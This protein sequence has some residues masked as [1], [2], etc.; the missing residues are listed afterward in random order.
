MDG[1]PDSKV[2]KAVD[3]LQ[4]LKTVQ[5]NWDNLQFRIR[6]KMPRPISRLYELIGGVAAFGGINHGLTI[7]GLR[8]IELPSAVRGT[9]S[10]QWQHPDLGLNIRDFT[11]DPVQDLLVII[12]IPTS[13]RYCYSFYLVVL[14]FDSHCSLVPLNPGSL[15]FKSIYEAYQLAMIIPLHLYLLF[16]SRLPLLTWNAVFISALWG[17]T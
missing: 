15:R 2:F 6:E 16:A 5:Y 9:L 17:T 13:M 8:F 7:R 4:C 3:R 10:R 1:D 12:G 14:F 11:I